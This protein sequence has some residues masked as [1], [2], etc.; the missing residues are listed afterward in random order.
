MTRSDNVST[1]DPESDDVA[2]LAGRFPQWWIWISDT[3]MWWASRR[4]PLRSAQLNAGL[5]PYL[6]AENP[7]ILVEQLTAQDANERGLA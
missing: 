2:V 3:S 4:A 7:A 5:V 6:R 1:V